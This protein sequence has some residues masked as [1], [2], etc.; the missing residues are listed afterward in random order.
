MCRVR[1]HQE[2]TVSFCALCVVDK[3]VACSKH[4]HAKKITGKQAIRL[5]FHSY[6]NAY[7]HSRDICYEEWKNKNEKVAKKVFEEFYKALL[8]DKKEV[9]HTPSALISI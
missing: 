3:I 2:N 4:F 6:S 7:V 1:N 9:Y 8:K 5:Y